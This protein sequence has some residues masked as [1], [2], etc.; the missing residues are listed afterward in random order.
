MFLTVASSLCWS[1]GVSFELYR[2]EV[3]TQPQ[4]NN[5]LDGILL[6]SIVLLLIPPRSPEELASIWRSAE[7]RVS[8]RDEYQRIHIRPTVITNVAH[9]ERV[10]CFHNRASTMAGFQ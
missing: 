1:H 4:V 3:T 9:K 6:T 5:W 7:V 10:R 2:W 8:S